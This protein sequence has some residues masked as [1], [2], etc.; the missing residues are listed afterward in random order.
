MSANIMDFVRK[1]QRCHLWLNETDLSR[2]KTRKLITS[3]KKR[4]GKSNPFPRLSHD[5]SNVVH[6]ATFR[7]SFITRRLLPSRRGSRWAHLT[8]GRVGN[9]NADS[10]PRQGT[11]LQDSP[12]RNTTPHFQ[13]LPFLL[14]RRS[15]HFCRTRPFYP[16]R[17]KL[18]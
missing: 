11:C 6:H 14:F 3:S 12:R 13:C 5:V 4:R 2:R 9:L 16:F 1:H 8:L 7:T 15:I 17:A 18:V 10:P